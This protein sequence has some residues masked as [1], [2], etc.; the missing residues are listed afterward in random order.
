MQEE[1]R[2][3][4]YFRASIDLIKACNINYLII[5]AVAVGV[6]GNIRV[7]ED[8]DLMIFV[9]RKDVKLILNKAKDFGFSFNEKNVSKQAKEV[10]VFKIFYKNYHLDF[11]ISSTELEKS[12]LKR[13]KKIRIFDRDVFVPSKED[14]LLFKIISGRPKDLLDAE[15]ICDRQ[16]GRLD[17][18]YL[19]SWA[20][21]LS[22]EAE[23]MR[24]YNTLEKFLK[25]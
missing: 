11:L 1:I 21:R 18:N 22:D 14:L 20:Q 19:E 24:I 16:K 9:S 3:S 10:G 23:D 12:A 4:D 17:I 2:F 13:R 15:S 8:L 25:K 5:G 6:W 7:T